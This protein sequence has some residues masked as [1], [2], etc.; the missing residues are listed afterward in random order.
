MQSSFLEGGLT[1]KV[2]MAQ[3]NGDLFPELI[4]SDQPFSSGSRPLWLNNEP[5]EPISGLVIQ[6]NGPVHPIQWPQFT[7]AVS[8][9]NDFTATWNFGDGQTSHMHHTWHNFSETGLYTIMLTLTNS[10]G[11]SRAETQILVTD[12]IT[13]VLKPIHPQ[14]APPLWPVTFL[15]A[16]SGDDYIGWYFGDSSF[17][18]ENNLNHVYGEPGVYT[19][20][21]LAGST[22]EHPIYSHITITTD[23]LAG[24]TI[25]SA[26]RLEVGSPVTLTASVAHGTPLTYSWSIGDGAI[27][28][29]P[30][31]NHIFTEPGLF[32]V[33]VTA[34]DH[35]SSLT[36]A[37]QLTIMAE[38]L[39][40]LTITPSDSF[41]VGAPITFTASLTSGTPLSYS[42][43]MG[44]GTVLTGPVV[45]HTFTAY[46]VYTVSVTVADQQS[47]LT[48]TIQ[49]GGF[50]RLYLPVLVVAPPD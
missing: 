34:S 33:S 16:I 42:W 11:S 22:W 36:T 15:A 10:L 45:S 48:A 47:S 40:G 17:G 6:P 18:F 9:G 2:A 28:T 37:S 26:G 31:V 29:G 27:L 7:Y 14:Y 35:Q 41:R 1:N 50:Y 49:F 25:T 8:S 32:T 21:L 24:L 23:A 13:P 39:A 46:G 20:T 19:V 43:S 4:V 30:V 3:L 5:V 44:D 38:P 12:T